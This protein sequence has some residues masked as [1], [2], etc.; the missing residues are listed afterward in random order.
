MQDFVVFHGLLANKFARLNGRENFFNVLGSH[1]KEVGIQTGQTSAA[2]GVRFVGILHFGDRLGCFINHVGGQHG[3]IGGHVF[4]I[5]HHVQT[6]HATTLA[7]QGNLVGLLH[8]K[9]ELLVH[10]R[11]AKGAFDLHAHCQFTAEGL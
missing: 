5:T 9:R 7:A 2:H 3:E 11:G 1:H 8:G 10:V 4:T 6:H